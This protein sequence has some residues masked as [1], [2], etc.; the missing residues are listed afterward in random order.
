M[1]LAPTPLDGAFLVDLELREDERGFFARSWCREEFNAAGLDSRLVQC[2]VSWNRRRGTLRGMHWQ[3]V[4]HA[5]AKLVRV[6]A[7]AVLDVI[8]DLRRD[9]H[10]Y[11]QHVEVELTEQNR[12]AVYVPAGFAHGFQTLVDETEVFYQMSEYYEPG[13]QRGARWD[14]SAFGLSWPI[15]PPIVSGRD[16]VFPDFVRQPRS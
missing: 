7:G 6:T 3:E 9:S 1:R 4:P 2:N 14:D 15:R 12:R 10:T 11:L 16:A 13:S 5:E 8:V